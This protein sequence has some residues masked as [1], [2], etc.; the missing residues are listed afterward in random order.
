MAD[1]VISEE[2]LVALM[3]QAVRVA[4]GDHPCRFHHEPRH[5]DH[6]MG[7]IA[8]VGG[9]DGRA[10]VETIRE[11]HKRLSERFSPEVD[12]EYTAN[13]KMMT[14]IRKAAENSI[15]KFFGFAFIGII[16]VTSIGMAMIFLSKVG[17]IL[18][19]GK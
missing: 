15:S 12:E 13:H 1:V 6:V 17:P 3:A 18:G 16:V 5:I 9:G 7:M 4:L 11:H 14:G 8:D 19:Q 10:G 2:R